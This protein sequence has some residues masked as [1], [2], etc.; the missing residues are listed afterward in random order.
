MKKFY[1]LYAL[2]LTIP[3]TIFGV[4]GQVEI[5]DDSPTMANVEVRGDTFAAFV[6]RIA[7]LID[8]FIKLLGVLILFVFFFQVAIF[9]KKTGELRE[10][11]SD[12]ARR[13]L[14]WPIIILLV[15]FS[16]WGILQVARD[17]LLG[18]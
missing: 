18:V 7:D 6:T 14:L 3:D 8:P 13:R 16:I 15:L 4:S 5:P 1:L 12:E 9:I 2:L 17:I 10:G 11:H